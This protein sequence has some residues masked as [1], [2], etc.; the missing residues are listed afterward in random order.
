MFTS[1]SSAKVQRLKEDPRVALLVA[2]PAGQPEEWVALDGEITFSEEG[3]AELV[4]RLADRYWDLD[5]PKTRNTLDGW[6]NSVDTMLRLTLSPARIR[7][8]TNRDVD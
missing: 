5:D 4:S 7:S 8:Y 2:R 3:V 6:L 1:K